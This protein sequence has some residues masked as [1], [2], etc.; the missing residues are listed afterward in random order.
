MKLI[1]IKNI[2]NNTKKSI[3]DNWKIKKQL[4]SYY[5]IIQILIIA[6]LGLYSIISSKLILPNNLDLII[7]VDIVFDALNLSLIFL[8][9][10][11]V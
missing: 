3:N 5:F 1:R 9:T 8:I 7:N 4:F 11:R 10:F 2:I 6:I